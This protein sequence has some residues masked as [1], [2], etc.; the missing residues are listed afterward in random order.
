MKKKSS[1]LTKNLVEMGNHLRDLGLIAKTEKNAY[2]LQDIK[3]ALLPLAKAF[4]ECGMEAY[5]VIEAS[6]DPVKLEIKEDV[7]N[8]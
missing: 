1:R 3:H 7:S 6:K 8:E 4:A 2:T 5:L